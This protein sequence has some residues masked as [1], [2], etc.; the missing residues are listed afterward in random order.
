M[1]ELL[2]RGEQVANVLGV[3]RSWVSKQSRQARLSMVK[4]RRR[5]RCAVIEAWLRALGGGV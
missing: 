4:V 5:C 2:L 1:M 3:P